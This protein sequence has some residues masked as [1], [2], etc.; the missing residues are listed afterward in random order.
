M[1][2]LLFRVSARTLDQ[3][4]RGGAG[5]VEGETYVQ[6][7]ALAFFILSPL[8]LFAFGREYHFG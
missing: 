5:S 1:T 8:F 3:A 6:R 4:G 7:G 2:P